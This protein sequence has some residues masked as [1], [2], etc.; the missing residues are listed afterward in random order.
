MLKYLYTQPFKA[1]LDKE[2]IN[3]L[4]KKRLSRV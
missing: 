3:I 4:G 1:V 2:N